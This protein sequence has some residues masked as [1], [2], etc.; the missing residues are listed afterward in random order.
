MNKTYTRNPLLNN[1]M[2]PIEIVL[3]PEWWHKHAGICFDRDFFFHPA[4]RLEDEQKM[5]K[6]L[7]DKWGQFGAGSQKDQIRPEVGA[8]HLAAGY[9]ISEMLGCQV[10]YTE[11]HPPQVVPQGADDL[12]IVPERAFQSPA[13][14]DFQKLLDE[15]QSRY[16]KLYGDVNWSGVLNVALDLRGQDVFID[17]IDAPD[18]IK[19]DFSGIGKTIEK[20][21]EMVE[22]RTGTSSISVNRNI[23]HF[24]K[25]VFLHSECSHTMI[26]EA[27][28]ERFL[29]PI[30]ISWSQRHRPFGI[31]YCGADPHRYAQTFAKLPHLDFLDVGW[32]GNIAELRKFLPN[33]FLNIRLSPV[34]IIEQSTDDIH[35]IITRLV[36]ESGNPYLTGV[37]CINMDDQVGDEKI[38]VIYKTVYE[39][40]QKYKSSQ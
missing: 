23:R 28:Y 37:C 39:L 38:N 36:S 17:M 8:V 12:N 40:R 34:E 9:M 2:L 14:Q 35:T 26:A 30:D 1:D 4:R 16:G 21:V 11:N 20:F 24:D 18:A 6:V 22:N 13:F 27:D 19:Q 3:A 15:L 29:M 5:E 32:G 33:T 31:H 7:N 10:R 25:P